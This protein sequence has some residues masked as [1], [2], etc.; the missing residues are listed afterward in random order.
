VWL[1]VAGGTLAL[2]GVH[3]DD[4]WHTD[5]GRDSFFVPPHLLLYAG[6]L[7]V[8]VAVGWWWLQVR[9]SGVRPWSVQPLRLAALGALATFGSAPL[10][11]LW[12]RWFG[13][14]AVLW[15]PPHLLGVMATVTLAIGITAGA[16]DGSRARRWQ[17]A[18]AGALV[19]GGLL[20]PVMEYEADVPQFSAVWYLP[21]LSAGVL[22]AREVL[23]GLG[24]RWSATRSA[25][26]LTGFQLVLIAALAG[27]D[28][29]RPVITPVAILV[30]L[31][32]AA[33]RGLRLAA[34]ALLAPLLVYLPVHTIQPGGVALTW[35][36]PLT[37]VALAIPAIA[38]VLVLT[39]GMPSTW[40]RSRAFAAVAVML[41]A[42]LVGFVT[43][44]DAWAHDP[45]QGNEV[46]TA[47]IGV[48]RRAGHVAISV[49]LDS[50]D[51]TGYEP[52]RAVGRRGG[53]TIV[54]PLLEV[55][56]CRFE[57]ELLLHRA[58]RWFVYAELIGPGGTA[59]E[60]WLPIGDGDG[61]ALARGRSVYEPP[62]PRESPMKAASSIAVT[63]FALG[64]AASAIRFSTASLRTPAGRSAGPNTGDP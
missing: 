26:L 16:T 53:Q 11:E 57:G 58:G 39:R 49:T 47:E 42:P 61:E 32:D 40:R 54:G 7:L 17:V 30:V 25:L 23:T 35:G 21:A 1:A 37:S 9:A 24:G 18:A 64:L 59:V 56:D 45:G 19:L 2:A 63:G 38:V 29:S 62:S 22:A 52:V 43:A 20:V 44:G 8:T 50:P 41:A 15:S 48:E 13:R 3:W 14:D 51:C 60:T 12:H 6:T 46:T 28:F 27:A 10:D 55:D 33:D 5:R 4:A 36:E 31:L 34:C